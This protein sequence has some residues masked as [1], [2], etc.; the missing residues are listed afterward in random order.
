VRRLASLSVLILA[1]CASPP[2][3]PSGP[4]APAWRFL[5]ATY[6]A[7]GDGRIEPAEYT[8]SARNFA[9]LDADGDGHVTA[10]DFDARF[11]GVPR[12]AGFAYGEGGPEV[13]DPAPPF[14]LESTAGQRIACADF[15]GEKPVVLVFGSFT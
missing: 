15:A 11:D 13:G 3:P 8:R 2:P 12:V 5:R 10:A 7:D 4:E 14:A 6:D 1:A 9:Y